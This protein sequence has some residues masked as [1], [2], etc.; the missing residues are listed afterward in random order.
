VALDRGGQRLADRAGASQRPTTTEADLRLVTDQR[1]IKPVVS[2]GE[3]VMFMLPRGA[4][5]IRLISCAQPP[6]EARPWLSDQRRLGVRVKRIVLR[7]GDETREIPMDHPAIAR[8]WWDIGVTTRSVQN[9]TL[10]R[11]DARRHD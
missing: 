6:T 4:S 5:Q 7:D 11:Q 2:D 10:R 3:H 1:P 8:G 9:R